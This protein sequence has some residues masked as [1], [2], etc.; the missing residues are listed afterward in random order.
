MKLLTVA[1]PCYNSQEYMRKCIDSLLPGGED[2]EIIIINDG[3]IDNTAII[4]DEY[5]NRYP[6]IVKVIHQKN[7]GHGGAIN[8]G[9]KSASGVYFKVVDS[10]DW[11]DV[12]AYKKVLERL[13]K[14]RNSDIYVDMMISNF[15]YDKEGSYRKTVMCYENILP[16]DTM[17]SWKDMGRFPK[18]KYILMHSVIYRMEILIKSKII[19]PE[20]TFYVDNLFVY[21]PLPYVKT[22]YYLSV[23]LY[24]YYIGREDQSVN[25]S[26]MI[27]RI[28]QQIKVNKLMLELVNIRKIKSRHLRQFMFNYLAIITSVTSV[29]LIR[30]GT[31]ENFF[32]KRDFWRYVKKE[33]LKL[34]IKLRF[35]LLGM[36]SNLPGRIGRKIT[37][38]FYRISKQIYGF[39]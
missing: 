33:D 20:K 21:F 28:D 1:V 6:N 17:F 7:K 37:I 29:L 34:Y 2:V 13:K 25:E 5:A 8:S 15:V 9:I 23:D 10:D 26:I 30:S 22:M 27:K 19:L 32:K 18:H 4:A 11:V 39:N 3:S 14:L 36:V 16:E 38:T 24:R 31:E 35:G 12:E